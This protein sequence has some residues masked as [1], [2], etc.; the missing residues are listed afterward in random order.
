MSETEYSIPS[1]ADQ[2]NPGDALTVTISSMTGTAGTPVLIAST[3]IQSALGGAGEYRPTAVFNYNG[4]SYTGSAVSG[5]AP[6]NYLGLVRIS[7]SSITAGAE[8]ETTDEG[9]SYGVQFDAVDGVVSTTA[10]ASWTQFIIPTGIP[11]DLPILCVTDI[12][13]T[14]TTGFI[15]L[16]MVNPDGV[17]FDGGLPMQ[18]SIPR[19]IPGVPGRDGKRKVWAR[20]QFYSKTL[21][22]KAA[23]QDQLMHFLVQTV[24]NARTPLTPVKPTSCGYQSFSDMLPALT[25]STAAASAANP[26]RVERPPA[27]KF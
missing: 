14:S 22:G 7:G 23:K 26:T 10:A 24:S 20:E 2:S 6:G 13:G 25:I 12:A 4:A 17:D 16:V 15:F 5:L 1:V 9:D 19:R 8:W 21:Q 18:L 27:R 3:S 11:D